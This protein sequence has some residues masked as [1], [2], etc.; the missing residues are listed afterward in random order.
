MI[1]DEYKIKEESFKKLKLGSFLNILNVFVAIVLGTI[2][3]YAVLSM[4][5]SAVS[6]NIP[7][8]SI[9]KYILIKI[10]S[11][12]YLVILFFAVYILLASI[13]VYSIYLYSKS[14]SLLSAFNDNLKDVAKFTKYLYLVFIGTDGAA[15]L[16]ILIN[17]IFIKNIPIFIIYVILVTVEFFLSLYLFIGIYRI[18]VI[19]NSSTLRLGTIF[20]FIPF[21][22]LVAPFLLYS[23]SKKLIAENKD[24]L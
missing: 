1:N 22:N 17:F 5:F 6:H 23:G 4:V 8:G 14:V 21:L 24:R 19:Y 18:G 2:V 13:E 12:I 16:E 9:G 7:P 11:D 10:Y 15:I 3:A 20:Y